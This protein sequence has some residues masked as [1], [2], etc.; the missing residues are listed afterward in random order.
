MIDNVKNWYRIRAYQ[1][2]LKKAKK[3]LKWLK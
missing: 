2:E 3:E 1:A